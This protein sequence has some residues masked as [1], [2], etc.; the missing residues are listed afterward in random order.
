M[1]IALKLVEMPVGRAIEIAGNRSPD[2]LAA[3]LENEPGSV[4]EHHRRAVRRTENDAR[5]PAPA[6]GDDDR[7]RTRELA[8]FP[9]QL[10]ITP[11]SIRG[12]LGDPHALDDLVR[13][14]L[15]LENPRAE[16]IA[17]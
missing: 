15:C 10:Q 1:K 12:Q 11:A 17:F 4:V 7:E 13:G 2:V 14:E 9:A 8:R 3:T 6:I 16:L 5:M